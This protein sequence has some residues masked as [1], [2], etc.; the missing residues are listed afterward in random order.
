M[1]TQLSKEEKEKITEIKGGETTV[2]L[3]KEEKNRG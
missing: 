2:N 3:K 1:N